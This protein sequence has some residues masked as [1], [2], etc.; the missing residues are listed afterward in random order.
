MAMKESSIIQ[1][2]IQD[3]L[4]VNATCIFFY[5]KNEVVLMEFGPYC[6]QRLSFCSILNMYNSQK[7]IHFCTTDSNEQTR[8]SKNKKRNMK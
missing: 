6:T 3:L 7:N 8:V 4:T 1:Y 5:E 2:S